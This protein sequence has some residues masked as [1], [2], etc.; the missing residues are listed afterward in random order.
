MMAGKVVGINYDK[1]SEESV[2]LQHGNFIIISHWFP[3]QR[4][5]WSRQGKVVDVTGNTGCGTGEHLSKLLTSVL[6][7]GSVL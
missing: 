1:V 4:A 6:I 2:I 3:C 7:H 5:S